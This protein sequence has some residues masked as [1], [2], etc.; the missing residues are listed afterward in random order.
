MI[1]RKGFKFRLYP[2]QAQAELLAVQFGHKR[3]IYNWR[4]DQSRERYP[5]YT[6]LA[7]QLPEMK[8][9][10]EFAWLKAAYSQVLQQAL[11]DLNQ[12]FVNFFEKRA[13]YPRFKGKRARQS[14]RYPQPKADWIAAD[15]RRIKLPR[16][17]WVK[18]NIHRPLEG[19]MKNVTVSRTK[20]GQYFVSINVEV[21]TKEPEVAGGEVGIDLGL[22]DFVTLSTGEKVESEEYLRKAERQRR[23][24]ARWLSRKQPGG[25]NQEKA[26]LK[27]AR[28]DAHIANQRRDFHH[29]LSRKLVEDHRLA[30]SIGDAGWSAF[31][32]MLEYKGQWYPSSRTCSACGIVVES[33]PLNIREWECPECGT[34][35]DRDVNA[36]VNILKQA[37]VGITGS[38]GRGMQS[39]QRQLVP[40]VCGQHV[41]PGTA[42]AAGQAG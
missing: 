32:K 3:F 31:A 23:R 2:N 26:R 24:L 37:T 35:H 4:I 42:A 30:G 9:S 15:H 27:L 1:V 21:E 34:I 33:L 41:R 38:P 22:C 12:A 14:I 28:L 36:A 6:T 18:V 11:I 19:V 16:V 8:A 10:E 20:S 5:G 17:G 29:K 25:R 40:A 39:S 13:G 7:D